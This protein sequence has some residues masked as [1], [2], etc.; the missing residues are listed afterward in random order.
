MGRIGRS[1]QFFE[2]DGRIAGVRRAGGLQVERAANHHPVREAAGRHGAGQA[3]L[4]RDGDAVW[5]RCDRRAGRES[6]RPANE[7]RGESGSPVEL[8]R[9]GRDYAGIDFESVR[10]RPRQDGVVRRFVADLVGIFAGGA[11][12]CRGYQGHERR[13]LPH[14]DGHDHVADAWGAAARDPEAVSA[15]QVAPVGVGGQRRRARR[16]QAGFRPLR[17]YGVSPRTR[18]SDPGARFGFPRERPRTHSLHEAVLPPAQARHRSRCGARGRR[19]EPAVR[20]RADADGDRFERGSPVAVAR[21]AD[22]RVRTRAGGEAGSRRRRRFGDASDRRRRS[23]SKAL[24][25][26][27]RGTAAVRW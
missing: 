25:R 3:V 1:P 22:R 12:R 14:F 24:R 4:F 6:R 13:R 19:N 20:G 15:G 8:G 27:C 5:R 23:G 9:R 10:S 11:G 17:Q 16:R 26:I 18:R 7:P 2:V 21:F